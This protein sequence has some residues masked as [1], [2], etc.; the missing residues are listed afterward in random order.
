MSRKECESPRPSVLRQ[1]ARQ[2]ADTARFGA[3]TFRHVSR[4]TRPAFTLVELL[5]VM[6]IIAAL[7]GLLFPAV[8]S[9]RESARRIT[10]ANNMKQLGLAV[11]QHETKLTML[12]S[13][14]EGY[15]VQRT[16]NGDGTTTSTVSIIFDKQ[17]VLTR[18]LPYLDHQLLISGYDMSKSYRDTAHAPG[19][20]HVAQQ[21]IPTYLC[22]SNP[23]RT[24]ADPGDFGQTDYLATAYSDINP[25]TGLR[26]PNM[27][28]S[29]ALAAPGVSLAAVSDGVSETIMFIEDAGRVH[30]SQ[31]YHT[32]SAYQDE[33]CTNGNADSADCAATMFDTGGAPQPNGHAA[34]RW[35]DPAASAGGISGP[36]NATAGSR[37]YITQNAWP[38]GGPTACPWS[39][40]NCGPNEEPFAFHPG[41]CNTAFCDGS[42]RFLGERIDSQSLRALVTRAE[43]TSP[44]CVPQ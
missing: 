13:G 37:N 22:P 39:T 20:V 24:T 3:A 35:A 33:D 43:G 14:G 31:G 30:S 6:S 7:M 1:T 42:V 36:P 17:S 25:A 40:F 15:T 32:A 28:M 19:N 10:C 41:G 8:Q 16:P 9:A 5:V 44:G 21:K 27:T 12:P 26:D 23:Y 18:I 38:T 2:R 34:N 29:G 4:T 11:L